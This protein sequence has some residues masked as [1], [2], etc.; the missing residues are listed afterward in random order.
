MNIKQLT[1]TA[2]LIP[3]MQ[4]SAAQDLMQVYELALEQDAVLLVAE[5]EY[6]AATESVS[7]ANSADKPQ[8]F[9]GA[10]GNLRES[11]NSDTG[12]NTNTSLGA[13]VNLR[14]SLYN[15]ETASSI[16]AAES[17]AVA[18]LAQLE[19]ARQDLILRVAGAYFDVLAAQDTVEFADAEK[20]AISRQLEQAQKR[21]EVGLIAI[22]DV[23]EAQARFDSAEAQVI[24]ANNQLEN[25]FQAMQVIINE[26]PSRQPARLGENL[27]LDL[28]N[29]AS[30]DAWVDLALE[31]N[32]D[33][34]AARSNLDAT[35]FER[36]QTASNDDPTIDF[37]ASFGSSLTDD[38]RLGEFDQTDLVIG[39]ELE[40][41]L[42]TGGRNS[43]LRSQAEANLSAAK[44]Q[45]LLQTRLVNQETRNAYLGVVSGISQVRA[46]KQALDSSNVALEATQAGFEVGTR[47][48]VDVLVS[49]QETYRAERDYA[50]ARYAYLLNQLNLRAAAGLL[51]DDDLRG[52]NRWLTD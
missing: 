31:N 32:K 45:L 4:T 3:A 41:P 15:R 7:I 14:Q 29:P 13:S 9:L 28:P 35:R 1:L 27:T 2:L 39:V 23:Q 5:S 36:D 49:L 34:A 46:L 47:T 43:A 17:A 38:D 42:F 26:A 10:Q 11:D 50:G 33:L 51:S 48:S 44:N 12:D 24:V 18:A 8:V 52:I 21:F 37:V 19:S 22:T 20:T 40:M 30:A 16:S 6:Q 25:A